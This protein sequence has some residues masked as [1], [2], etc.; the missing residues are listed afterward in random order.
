[1]RAIQKIAE[2]HILNNII[3]DILFAEVIPTAKG[4]DE[5]QLVFLEHRLPA[6]PQGDY[7]LEL[8]QTLSKIGTPEIFETEHTLKVDFDKNILTPEDIYNVFPPKKSN[9]DYHNILP[10]LVLNDSSFPWANKLDIDAD[11]KSPSPWIAL[12]L[13]NEDDFDVSKTV[14]A[15]SKIV[16]STKCLFE[17]GATALTNE[18]IR[19]FAK[20]TCALQKKGANA[21]EFGE[22]SILI[23]NSLPTPEKQNA[24]H[25]IDL[26]T[27]A[28]EGLNI[29]AT[30]LFHWQF[31]SGLA[32]VDIK[33]T[34]EKASRQH[35]KLP[36]IAYNPKPNISESDLA[37]EFE[38]ALSAISND[39]IGKLLS[40]TDSITKLEQQVIDAKEAALHIS[41]TQYLKVALKEKIAKEIDAKNIE[42]SLLRQA[43][44]QVINKIFEEQTITRVDNAETILDNYQYDKMTI[45]TAIFKIKFRF[46]LMIYFGNSSQKTLQIINKIKSIENLSLESL[47]IPKTDNYAKL[48]SIFQED[49]KIATELVEATKTKLEDCFQHINTKNAEFVTAIENIKAHISDLAAEVKT[50]SWAGSIKLA[51]VKFQS[52]RYRLSPQPSKEL[53]EIFVN[54]FVKVFKHHNIN[55]LTQSGFSPLPHFMRRGTK[56]VSMYRSPFVP[57]EVNENQNFKAIHFPDELYRFHGFAQMLDATYVAAWELGRMLTLQD[58]HIATNIYKWKRKYI[59][60]KKTEAQ[61]DPFGLINPANEITENP[62]FARTVRPWLTDLSELKNIPFNYIIPYE[63]MLPPNSI[64]FF[65]IDK[66]WIAALLDGALS[67]GRIFENE[68]IYQQEIKWE[69]FTKISEKTLGTGCLI[70]SQVIAD[71]PD[72]QIIAKDKHGTELLPKTIKK[73]SSDIAYCLFDTPFTALEVF[74]KPEGIRFGIQNSAQFTAMFENAKSY[75]VA[76][77]AYL[78]SPKIIIT[79][80]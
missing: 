50:E 43:L 62:I 24:V 33:E 16:F 28:F 26:K 36:L 59:I 45:T 27:L 23:C 52:N 34:L 49:L 3:N 35:L 80:S 19:Q 76:K 75:Q 11:T 22:K 42:D 54:I 60:E 15:G 65:N 57:V 37:Q 4:V 44:W 69:K 55:T 21:T 63:D 32:K 7:K 1:M 78:N 56:T 66:S 77:A 40:L 2:Q 64:R 9:S 31:E 39:S 29:K 5:E 58:E 48:N 13:L 73:L 10:H 14:E 12:V 61:L 47:K 38:K 72:L 30:S 51:L 18:N 71:Y 79:N 6:L 67:V 20:L 53:D 25:L 68:E 8:K 17:N 74:L 70:R 41:F 46:A